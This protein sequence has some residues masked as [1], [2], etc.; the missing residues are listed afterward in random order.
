MARVLEEEGVVER[1]EVQAFDFACLYAIQEINPRIAT[2][3]LTEADSVQQMSNPDPRIAGL[4][5][6]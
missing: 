1:T 2:Q 3:Y 4:W 5:T 6:G